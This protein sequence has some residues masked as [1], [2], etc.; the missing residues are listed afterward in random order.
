MN[1]G[2]IILAAA[3]VPPEIGERF[4][5]RFVKVSPVV[6]WIQLPISDIYTKEYSSRLHERLA[7]K[8]RRTEP[9][10]RH[11]LLRDARLVLLY[12]DRGD[13]SEKHL[14]SQFGSEA[15]V[16]PFGFPEM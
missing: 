13:G 11:S 6:S 9:S 5:Q 16:V 1:P 10:D 12:V 14:F 15:L 7:A 8:L 2:K 3:G 4:V